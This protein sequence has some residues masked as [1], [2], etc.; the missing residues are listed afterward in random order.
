MPS[1]SGPLFVEISNQIKLALDMQFLGFQMFGA[2]KS[3]QLPAFTVVTG[4]GG[5]TMI[6][7]TNTQHRTIPF[8]VQIATDA[9]GMAPLTEHPYEPAI[10]IIERLQ[11]LFEGAA[12]KTALRTACPAM[13]DLRFM[14][15]R[16]PAR[17]G[18]MVLGEVEY[19]TDIKY[20]F[21]GA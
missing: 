2:V 7:L 11:V 18:G 9:P 4:F 12:V 15:A 17:V 5:E 1:L 8:T 21:T 19:E 20:D 13:M 10:I 3:L 14:D 16:G 6:D